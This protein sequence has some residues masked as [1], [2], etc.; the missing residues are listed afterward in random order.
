[1]PLSV[2]STS[3]YDDPWDVAERDSRGELF[4]RIMLRTQLEAQRAADAATGWGNDRVLLYE[5]G[6][7]EN[8]FVWT[9]RWDD[10]ANATEFEEAF[11]DYLNDRGLYDDGSWGVDGNEFRL[12]SIDDRTIAVVAGPTDFVAGVEVTESGDTVQVSPPDDPQETESGADRDDDDGDDTGGDG[13][14]PDPGGDDSTGDDRTGE[15]PRTPREDGERDSD[16][17]DGDDSDG[18]GDGIDDPLLP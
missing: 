3:S 17:S 18:D 6:Y 10:A 13:W 2:R 8:A 7:E 11:E 15:D 5:R 16:D 1:V 4:V 14:G 9:L 12:E